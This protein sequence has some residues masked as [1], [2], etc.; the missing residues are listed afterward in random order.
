MKIEIVFYS[1]AWFKVEYTI[2]ES[3]IIFKAWKIE[4]LSEGSIEESEI[5]D[6]P[7]LTGFI[8]WDGCC[9]FNY[10][11]HYCE[12]Y[13]AEQF[14]FLMKEIYNYKDSNFKL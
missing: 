13:M 1:E 8:K 6:K 11:E 5:E 14:Y 10:S 9:E 12:I 2:K 3:M 7:C 4:E